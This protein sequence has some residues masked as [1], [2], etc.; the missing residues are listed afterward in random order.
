MRTSRIVDAM[1]YIDDDLVSWAVGYQRVPL[2]ARLQRSSFLRAGAFFLVIALI[3]GFTFFRGRDDHEASSPFTLSVYAALPEDGSIMENILEKGVQ[4]PIS[5]FETANGLTG[6]VVSCN[7]ADDGMPSSIAI[8][9]AENARGLIEEIKGIAV[10]P[11][12]NYFF[13]I[14]T[15]KEAEPYILPLLLNDTDADLFYRYKVRISQID[16]SYYAELIVEESGEYLAPES[17]LEVTDGSVISGVF[18]SSRQ[19]LKLSCKEEKGRKVLYLDEKEQFS[20]PGDAAVRLYDIAKEDAWLELVVAEGAVDARIGSD[21]L[22]VKVYRVLPEGLKEMAVFPQGKDNSFLISDWYS[23]SFREGIVETQSGLYHLMPAGYLV[24]YEEKEMEIHA[25]GRVIRLSEKKVAIHRE[26]GLGIAF[27]PQWAMAGTVHYNI[28]RTL[29]GG[30]GWS[31]IVEDF[32]KEDAEFD[33]ILITEENI[34][35]CF[36]DL[37]GVTGMRRILVSEDGGMTWSDFAPQ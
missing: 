31:L 20:V 12:K 8:I 7:K 19:I 37:S 16:G 15:E 33:H 13:Y 6:F 14:P 34:I 3:F 27:E 11:A 4:V 26:S 28:Y 1:N 5:T 17:G 30:A 36:F 10:D 2:S 18:D 35:Y 21:C 9:S 25:D 22:R 24:P 23:L 29:D 32:M